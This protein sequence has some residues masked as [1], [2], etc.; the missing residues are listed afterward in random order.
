[1]LI[2]SH[3]SFGLS[4]PLCSGECSVMVT[5]DKT[6]LSFLQ[7]GPPPLPLLGYRFSLRV[8]AASYCILVRGGVSLCFCMRCHRH[9]GP[10]S[11]CPPAHLQLFAAHRRLPTLSLSFSLLPGF[12]HH[13]ETATSAPPVAVTWCSSFPSSDG[14]F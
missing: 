5:C 7:F 14:K 8:L 1:M 10:C 3:W 6:W 13:L 2:V 9:C 11:H 12:L 4:S